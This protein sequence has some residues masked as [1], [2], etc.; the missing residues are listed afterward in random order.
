MKVVKALFLFFAYSEN[1]HQCNLW[2]HCWSSGLLCVQGW[3]VLFGMYYWLGEF[4]EFDFIFLV[5]IVSN[6]NMRFLDQRR[7]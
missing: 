3:S 7:K 6:L 2:P 5:C 1:L 4:N